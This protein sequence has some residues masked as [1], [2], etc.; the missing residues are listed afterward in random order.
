MGFLSPDSGFMRG[1][2]DLVDA[3]W[4]NMLMLVTGLPLVTIGAALSAGHYAARRSLQ[5]RGHVTADFFHAFRVEFVQSTCI[6]LIL[7]PIGCLLICG[8]L[9]VRV[10]LLLIPGF[11]LGLLW[12][13]IFEWVWSL[14]AGFENTIMRTMLNALVI[15]VVN[16]PRTAALV[17]IDLAYLLLLAVCWFRLPQGLFLLVILGYGTLLMLHTPIQKLTLDRYRTGISRS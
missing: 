5:G 17:V 6:W 7:G 13:I 4:I 16:W 10:P 1:L 12:V 2:S 14:Q 11:A 8:W 9:L 3:V 15:G